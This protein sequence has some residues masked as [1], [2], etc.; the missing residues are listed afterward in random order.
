MSWL[1]HL[2]GLDNLIR[3]HTCH[4]HRCPRIGRH[5]VEGTEYV[6]CR[7]HHPDGAPT[8]ADVVRRHRQHVAPRSE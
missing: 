7:R 2:L 3:K 1:G 4:V 6:V 8:H 5:K